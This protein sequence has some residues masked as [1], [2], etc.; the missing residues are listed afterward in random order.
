MH[1]D[2]TVQRFIERRAQGWTCARLMSPVQDWRGWVRRRGR[3]SPQAQTSH[4]VVENQGSRSAVRGGD[5]LTTDR[6]PRAPRI[7]AGISQT[8]SRKGKPMVKFRPLAALLIPACPLLS[9]VTASETHRWYR[10]GR[11]EVK[12]LA[13]SNH[14]RQ[15]GRKLDR[16]WSSA[17]AVLKPLVR[18]PSSVLRATAARTPE[19]VPRSAKKCS[20]QSRFVFPSLCGRRLRGPVSFR[21]HPW[22]DCFSR[23]D[24]QG[25]LPVCLL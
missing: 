11:E 10:K 5:G 2:Q 8:R 4:E 7:A 23:G 14:Q 9:V 16:F 1:D 21:A 24:W 12:F 17:C 6:L 25:D 22:L 18:S 15:T 20:D 13:L 3:T 19:M